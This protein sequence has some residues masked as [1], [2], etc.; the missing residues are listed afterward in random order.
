MENKIYAKCPMCD[1]EGTI[2]SDNCP[3]CNSFLYA[4]VSL[5]EHYSTREE[6][7]KANEKIAEL[8]QGVKIPYGEL[9]SEKSNDPDYPS[10]KI[11][12]DCF[13]LAAIEY[14]A[15]LGLRII[16]YTDM[17]SDEPTAT[18]QVGNIEAMLEANKQEMEYAKELENTK[19][20]NQ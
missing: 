6:L 14:N 8:E 10:I 1:F 7:K 19:A 13:L 16:L 12:L 5:F 9:V 18:I 4:D 15:D 3:T 2:S 20:K 11:Y 17:I